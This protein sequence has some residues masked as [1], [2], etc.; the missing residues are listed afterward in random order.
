MREEERESNVR[1]WFTLRFGSGKIT[2]CGCVYDRR[3]NEL[4]RAVDLENRER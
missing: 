4:I 1:W 3:V 2:G